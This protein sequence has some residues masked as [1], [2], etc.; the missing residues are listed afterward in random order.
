MYIV[1]EEYISKKYNVND[2][3][4]CY[5]VS[6]FSL[7]VAIFNPFPSLTPNEFYRLRKRHMLTQKELATFMNDHVSQRLIGLHRKFTDQ[8]ISRWENNKSRKQ[9]P[10]YAIKGLLALIDYKRQKRREFLRDYY[11]TC[12]CRFIKD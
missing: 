5:Y 2:E 7:F 4:S 9:I 1:D 8:T 6:H 11:A 10:F 12:R 3:S